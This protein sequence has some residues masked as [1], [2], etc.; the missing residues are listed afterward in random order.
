MQRFATP[1]Y[2]LACYCVKNILQGMVVTYLVG[3]ETSLE[4]HFHLNGRSIGLLLTLGEIGPILTA[5]VLAHVGSKGNRPRW[6]AIGLLLISLSLVLSFAMSFLFPV[7]QTSDKNVD[8]S[9]CRSNSIDGDESDEACVINVVQR[10]WAFAAW[11]VIYTVMGQLINIR[12]SL[13]RSIGIV[14]ISV[15]RIQESV[16]LQFTA[17]VRLISMMRYLRGTLL[18]TSVK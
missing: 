16:A 10:K 7:E 14:I 6:M 4:R 8:H 9:L 3:S 1:Q 11:L 15:I 13:N 12:S 2:F 5:V 18:F 17:L